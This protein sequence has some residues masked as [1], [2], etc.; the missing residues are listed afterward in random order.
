[1]PPVT[2]CLALHLLPGHVDVIVQRAD[3]QT[4]QNLRLFQLAVLQI[5]FPQPSR[6][7]GTRRSGPTWRV[8]VRRHR[9]V[10][11]HM[12]GPGTKSSLGAASGGGSA[13]TA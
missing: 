9:A 7:D 4:F 3:A 11:T 2:T 8:G 5:R 10:E 6:W 12:R 1:M 13:G